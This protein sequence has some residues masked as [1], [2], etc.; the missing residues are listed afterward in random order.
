MRHNPNRNREK[1]FY[2]KTTTPPLGKPESI[3][4]SASPDENLLPAAGDRARPVKDTVPDLESTAHEQSN[5]ATPPSEEEP[6]KSTV[7]MPVR[8]VPIADIRVPP[9]LT[10]CNPRNLGFLARSRCV[11]PITVIDT[12]TG[13]LLVGDPHWL[14][15]AKARGRSRV[16][17]L[18]TSAD[19]ID[20]RLTEI[21]EILHHAGLPVLD[22]AA[23]VVE[24]LKTWERR[25]ISGQDVQEFTVGRPHGGIA[26]AARV[27]C[28][29]GK[30]EEARRKSIERAITID[31][32]V[33]EAKDAAKRAGLDDVQSALLAIAN[34]ESAAQLAKV[35][36]L[37]ERKQRPRRKR[38]TAPDRAKDETPENITLNEKDTSKAKEPMLPTVASDP[39][40]APVISTT[41]VAVTSEAETSAD[42]ARLKVELADKAERL[43]KAEEALATYE[44]APEAVIDAP[45]EHAQQRL[46][47]ER[48][49]EMERLR[50][51][52]ATARA[53]LRTAT[54]E[55]AAAHGEMPPLPPFLQ[56]LDPVQ[57]ATVED[58]LGTFDREIMPK[59]TNTPDLVRD[60]FWYE[61]RQRVR[62]LM[63]NGG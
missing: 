23:L 17:C 10:P 38:A 35:R 50:A 2:G 49:V 59:L 13:P 16:E 9:G 57:Q 53:A 62:A 14:E 21:E 46:P 7:G 45:P 4:N 6:P 40:S 63:G 33:S 8:L 19:E 12:P 25:H 43:R 60:R 31:S 36:E 48:D 34:E 28:V 54:D 5:T 51:D 37:V 27:L 22:K 15:V 11:K 30:T 41:S 18:F 26:Q 24:W 52:L 20:A 29:P 44:V 61:I 39:P 47:E 55:L 56:R 58:L 42:M 32:I 3:P 1:T